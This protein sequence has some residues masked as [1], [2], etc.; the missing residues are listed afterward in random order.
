M[1]KVT[2]ISSVPNLRI[3]AMERI[4]KNFP[5]ELIQTPQWVLWKLEQRDEKTTKVPYQPNGLKASSTNSATWSDCQTVMLAFTKSSEYSGIG[6]V[7][8]ISDPYIGI[9]LDK[10]RDTAAGVVEP[11]AM[12]IVNRL[13]TYIELSPSGG[14]F[15]II[16]KGMLPKTGKRKDRIEMYDS[17]RYFTVTGDHY[18]DSPSDANDIQE[19]LIDLHTETFGKSDKPP[20]SK[21]SK[22]QQST[23]ETASMAREDKDVVATILTSS[24]A[25][26]FQQFLSGDWEALGYESQSEAD[27]AFAGMLVRHA[28]PYPDQID[29]VFRASGMFRDKWDEMRG[30]KTYGEMTIA[31]ALEGIAENKATQ[32]FIDKMNQR[33][34]VISIGNKT[35]ILDLGPN[36]TE[37]RLLS[38]PDFAT[39]TANVR[40]PEK[41][42]STSNY[43]LG[44]PDR[45]SYNGLIFLPGKNVPG[46]YNMWR[47]FAVSP[48]P[49]CSVLF[50]EFV[51]DV[52]CSGHIQLYQYI[53]RYFAHMIQRPW[54]RP[55][56]AI[57]L[58]GGQGTGKNTFVDTMGSLVAPYFRQVNSMDQITGRFNAHMQNTLL[59]HANEATW[60]GNKS[61]RGKLKAMI[62]DPTIP[63]EMKGLDI[64]DMNNYLRLVISSNEDWPVPVDPDDRRF[65][66]LDVSSVHQQDQAY[67][68]AIHAELVSGGREA[69]MHDLSVEP[70]AGFSPRSKPASPFGADMK[71]RSADAPVRW[72]YDILNANEWIQE[73]KVFAQI[74]VQV[75]VAKSE[76]YRDYEKWSHNSPERFPA[77]RDQFFK[78]IGKLLGKTMTT[79][80][81][82]AKAGQTRDRKLI[83]SDIAACRKAFEVATGTQGGISWDPV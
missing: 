8:T 21:P 54:E 5:E 34:A 26:T 43:W 1:G 59:L 53:R 71:L 64:V 14:G 29:R 48:V 38:R 56:V 58:R 61:E 68:A 72:L 65:L 46:I 42:V 28:G 27:L 9:D 39:Q 35:K 69:L 67:F 50:W 12:D 44:S 63:V 62:T 52:I 74:G 4:L 75:E 33:Y 77:G 49:G 7:F 78:T 47:G 60:G 13:D 17:G 18:G 24:D 2:A 66:V 82:A 30:D 79:S 25:A 15:H 40:S 6:F 36:G 16:G 20:K 41:G 83:L 23:I 81:P 19:T 11:W 73:G 57:V 22:N 32:Q 10:C 80:R 3:E 37:V 51:R 55:E 45:A 76:M 70:L 31:K